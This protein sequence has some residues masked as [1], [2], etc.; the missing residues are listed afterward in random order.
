MDCACQSAEVNGELGVRW[1]FGYAGVLAERARAEGL[2][3]GEALH[4]E[5]L[6]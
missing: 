3:V 5:Q 2:R 1:L 4:A 6:T